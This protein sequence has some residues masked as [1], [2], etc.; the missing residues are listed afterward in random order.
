MAALE[1]LG[2]LRQWDL[3]I[4]ATDVDTAMLKH[5]RRALYAGERLEKLEGE[6]LLRWFE[7]AAE[8]HHYRVCEEVRRLVSFK[9]LNLVAPWPMRGP[10]D[11]IFCRNVLMYFTRDTQREIVHRMAALQRTAT[12]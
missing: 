3:R 5:A 7:P 11:V 2:A 8:A 10:F 12:I 9:A 6:R 4:L 1:S